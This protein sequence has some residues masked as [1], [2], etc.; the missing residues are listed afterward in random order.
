MYQQISL[1]LTNRV[2][3]K[4]N[5]DQVC[6]SFTLQWDYFVRYSI[7]YDAEKWNEVHKYFWCF[8][9]KNCKLS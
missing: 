4:T 8:Q 9:E 5:R 1:K 2:S 6:F 3:F 7:W